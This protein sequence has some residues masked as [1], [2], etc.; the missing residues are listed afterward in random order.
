M[1]RV[2][3]LLLFPALTASLSAQAPDPRSAR[4]DSIFAVMD[5][6]TT[7]GCAVG[8][9]QDGRLVHRRG[10]GMAD[11]ERGVPINSE[12]VFYTGSVSKQFTAMAIA[13]LARDGKIS[14][15]DPARKY[16]PEIPEAGS[17]I[18][19]RQMVHHMSGLREKWDLFLLR[20]MSPGYLVTQND[21]LE[22]LKMQRDLNF[23]PGTEQ[24]YNNTAYDMLATIVERASGKSIR[25]YAAERIFGPL[26]M[27]RSQ[28]LDDWSIL[29]PGRAAGHSVANG[30]VSLMPAHVETVGSG[31]VYSTVEDLARW[32]ESFYT[33]QLGGEALLQL[34]QTPGKF[35]D[36]TVGPM[37]Y[38]FGLMI[39]TWRGLRRVHHGGALAG[40]RAMIM[41]F[42]DQRF[43]AIVLC[44]LA[45]INPQTY[46]E[47]VAEVYLGDKL[48]PSVAA[49]RPQPDAK[50]TEPALTGTALAAY[51][52]KYQSAELGITWTV[53]RKGD[54]LVATVV[55][56]REVPMKAVAKDRYTVDN[57]QVTF[58]RDAK[59]RVNALLLT[60]GRSR[61][62]RFDKAG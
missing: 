54:S 55:R 4:V 35:N 50:S 49:S 59:G 33:G 26:G 61:N 58:A 3:A 15:D 8:A 2:T 60:P 40:F 6:T 48:G 46:A 5:R 23:A 13:L 34:V 32:D 17:A 45:Q 18:T 30:K 51:A 56:G 42:P 53:T 12:T 44:N 11:L 24:M 25:E 39:D 62:I 28:Y 7:P 27:S 31:S 20:G 19:I 57:M 52:G 37:N 38:A 43:S 29:V 22:V 1:S 36:G 14:L 47:R 9:V 10:Y 21:V 16:I 41:R